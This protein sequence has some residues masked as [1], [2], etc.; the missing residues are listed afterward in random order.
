[1]QSRVVSV[2][3]AYGNL[4]IICDIPHIITIYISYFRRQCSQRSRV[5]NSL[6]IASCVPTLEQDWRCYIVKPFAD[7]L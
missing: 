5:S 6:Y 3:I 7:Y 4:I 1:M 2:I